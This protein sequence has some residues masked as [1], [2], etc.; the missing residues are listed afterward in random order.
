MEKG[1]T[2]LIALICI[3]GFVCAA[4]GDVSSGETDISPT[5][6]TSSS[7]NISSV[8]DVGS[9]IE[10]VLG[11]ADENYTDNFYLALVVG[12]VGILILLL[13]LYL[14]FRSPKNKWKD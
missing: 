11:V 5:I 4:W 6:N 8:G 14:F 9:N 3:I 1:F 10:D 7:L 13:L 12:S 2:L